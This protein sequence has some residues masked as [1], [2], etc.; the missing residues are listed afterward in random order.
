MLWAAIDPALFG[1]G[2][3]TVLVTTLAGY[4]LKQMT[5]NEQGTWSI[6]REL[7]RDNHRKDWRIAQLE[8]QNAQLRGQ[9]FQ[10]VDPGPYR[11]P[12]KEEEASW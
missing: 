11:A 8:Y 6:I 5:R 9:S 12:S 7:R 4:M 10:M 2:G 3:F 1:V